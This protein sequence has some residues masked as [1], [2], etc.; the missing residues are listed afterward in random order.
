MDEIL[1]RNCTFLLTGGFQRRPVFFEAA[2][3]R[4]SIFR[5]LRST[6]Q[7]PNDRFFD[8]DNELMKIKES[9]RE[10]LF[11]TKLFIVISKKDC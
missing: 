9:I 8:E 11:S 5:I 4:G 6:F 10:K 1:D 2:F 7:F 3:E